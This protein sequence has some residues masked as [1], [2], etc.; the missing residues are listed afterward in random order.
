MHLP[1]S[2]GIFTIRNIQLLE[3]GDNKIMMYNRNL[4][5]FIKAA[6]YGNLT[7]AAKT[8][9]ISQPAVS[10]ALSKLEEELGVKLFF[11]DKRNGM[12]L[13]DAGE[14]ILSLA[15]QMEDIDNRISQVAYKEQHFMGGRLR[16]ASLASLT[17]TIISKTLKQYQTRFPDIL[18]EIREGTPNDL[19]RMVEDHEVDFAVSCAPFWKFDSFSL[20]RDHMV[21]L[22]PD[23]QTA[24]KISLNADLGTLII[25]RPAYETILE[26]L[27]RRNSFRS[28]KVLL[29]QNPEAA[30][31]MVNDGIGIG[32][33]SE[34][35]LHSLVGNVPFCPVSPDISFDIGFFAHD[36]QDLT[37]AAAEFVMIMKQL[38]S[39]QTDSTAM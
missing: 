34:Y 17:S 24:E 3:M 29:V 27:P 11:R 21:A 31:H 33:V 13:T 16:I 25:N 38:H 10:N 12:I 20:I 28:D 15:K 14:K 30:I 9:Y 18:V 37:P 35:T 7:K 1:R 4:E 2:Y 39:P 26:Y 6:E 22:L 36:L 8:L 19:I 5:I 23:G 32:I